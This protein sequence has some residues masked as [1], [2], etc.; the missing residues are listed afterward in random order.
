MHKEASYVHYSLKRNFWE[1]KNLKTL[2]LRDLSVV[3]EKVYFIQKH[4]TYV[5]LE[6]SDLILK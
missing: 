1:K 2:L 4:L 6:K 3:S 5:L